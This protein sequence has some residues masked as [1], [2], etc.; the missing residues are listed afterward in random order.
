MAVGFSLLLREERLRQYP[1]NIIFLIFY[2]LCFSDLVSMVTAG[3]TPALVLGTAAL[4]TF[5]LICLTIYTLLTHKEDNPLYG[6]LYG[7]LIVVGLSFVGFGIL[8]I[9]AFQSII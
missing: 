1:N 8:Y 5:V 2:T 6:T 9:L 7:S 4:A 3:N